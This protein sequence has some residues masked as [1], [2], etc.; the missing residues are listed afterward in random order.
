MKKI[1]NYSLIIINTAFII[2]WIIGSIQSP[3]FTMFAIISILVL[4]MGIII[5]ILELKQIEYLDYKYSN[6]LFTLLKNLHTLLLSVGIILIST[7]LY[8]PYV[9]RVLNETIFY[10]GLTG[11]IFSIVYTTLDTISNRN[12]KL[13]K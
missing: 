6:V 7:S 2:W 10:I 4:T 1:I 5:A 12:L 9:V 11:L 13:Y 8:Y 3:M